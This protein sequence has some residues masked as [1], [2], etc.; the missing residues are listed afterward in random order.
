[1][2]LAVSCHLR[3]CQFNYLSGKRL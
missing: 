3:I 2:P 1:L